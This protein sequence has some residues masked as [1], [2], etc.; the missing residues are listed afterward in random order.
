MTVKTAKTWGGEN[1]L[2]RRQLGHPF[3]DRGAKG[4]WMVHWL[5][6][7]WSGP[8]QWPIASSAKGAWMVHW[9][10]I[11]WSGS[12]PMANSINVGYTSIMRLTCMYHAKIERWIS[13]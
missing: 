13:S 4:A 10:P 1:G 3:I 9:L 8:N 6:I 5:P 11:R 7:R 2:K 12:K